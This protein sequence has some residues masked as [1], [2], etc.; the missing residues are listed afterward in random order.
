[1]CSRTGVGRCRRYQS[2]DPHLAIQGRRSPKRTASVRAPEVLALRLPHP[3][4]LLASWDVTL[5]ARFVHACL[6]NL[7]VDAFDGRPRTLTLCPH[8][9]P[10]GNVLRRS[11]SGT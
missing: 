1:G 10:S 5:P 3:R 2:V 4:H 9:D 6:R 11:V 7:T 8:A